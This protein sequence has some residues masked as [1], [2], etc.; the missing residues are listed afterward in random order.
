VAEVVGAVEAEVKAE[1]EAVEVAE[2]AEAESPETKF[3]LTSSLA[4]IRDTCE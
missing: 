1:A 3:N 4:W 2:V